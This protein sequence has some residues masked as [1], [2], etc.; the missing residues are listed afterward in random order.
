MNQNLPNLGKEKDTQVQETQRVPNKLDPKRP[1]SKHIRSKMAKLKD[2]QR[3]IK[4][5]REKQIA[6]YKL[7]VTSDKI[8]TSNCFKKFKRRDSSQT[9]FTRPTLSERK[10]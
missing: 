8:V 6:T 3:T 1:T 5:V 7:Y 2:K 10:L 4:A 9:H